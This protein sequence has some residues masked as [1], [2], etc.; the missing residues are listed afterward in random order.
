MINEWEIFINH[1]KNHFTSS[2]GNDKLF[3][4]CFAHLLIIKLTKRSLKNVVFN[5]FILDLLSPESGIFKRL[6]WQPWGAE[7]PSHSPP[8]PFFQKY[9]SLELISVILWM[10][11]TLKT[12]KLKYNAENP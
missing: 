2:H 4:I 8:A 6:I 7:T 1:N 3:Y 9:K 11:W 5:Y 12:K 10:W